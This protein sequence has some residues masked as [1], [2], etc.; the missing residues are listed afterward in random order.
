MSDY[1]RD[2]LSAFIDGELPK[3]EIE[4]LFKRLDGNPELRATLARY[5]VIGETLRTRS[6][7]GPSRTFAERVR[8]AVRESGPLVGGSASTTRVQQ[9]RW[10]RP[11]AGMAVAATVAAVAILGLQRMQDP[12]I[13]QAPQVAASV[14]AQPVALDEPSA[15]SPAYPAYVVPTPGAG[16]SLVNAARLTNYVVAHS[17]YSSPLG[18][19]S[20]LS[21]IVAE[22]AASPEADRSNQDQDANAAAAAEPT[23]EQQ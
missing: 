20:V 15:D 14:T 1:L 8:A 2:Q 17:E 10:L 11:V 23:V 5:T 6:A 19:R 9:W 3:H 12:L 4:L 22:G 21:G 18:R 13:D 7:E 16:P